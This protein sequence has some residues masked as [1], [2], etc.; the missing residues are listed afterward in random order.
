MMKISAQVFWK[1]NDDSFL[2]NRYSRSHQWKFDGGAVCSASASPHIVRPPLSD[3]TFVDP[4]EAFVASIASC[5]MLWFLSIAAKN[6]CIIERYDDKAIGVMARND[7]GK[8]MVANVT[9][10]PKITW[11]ET[12]STEQVQQMHDDAHEECFIANSV[13]TKIFIEVKS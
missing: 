5:H 3:E 1:R 2:D 4:E 6:N 12:P 13:K 8:L 9:L 10:S 7:A 11:K